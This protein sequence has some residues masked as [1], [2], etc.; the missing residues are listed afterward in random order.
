MN[1]VLTLRY[2]VEYTTQR[3]K[4]GLHKMPTTVKEN[5]Y[6]QGVIR[7]VSLTRTLEDVTQIVGQVLWLT[8]TI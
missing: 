7:E 3:L 8:V 4:G 5:K 6:Y 2:S 1:P